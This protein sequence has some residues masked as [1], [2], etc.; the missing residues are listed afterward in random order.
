MHD[1]DSSSR[2]LRLIAVP[3]AVVMVLVGVLA[4]VLWQRLQLPADARVIYAAADCDLHAGPCRAEWPEGGW[5][6]LAIAPR[7]IEML[8]PLELSVRATGLEIEAARI[9]FAGEDMYMGYNRPVLAPDEDRFTGQGILPMCVTDSM[10]WRTTVLLDTPEGPI[11]AI[12]RFKTWR[13]QP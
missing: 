9:D 12:F 2:R 7:P 5:V 3:L 8:V 6:E 4:A 10:T 11:A 13:T 1:T